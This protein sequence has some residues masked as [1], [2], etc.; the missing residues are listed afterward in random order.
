MK[1]LKQLQKKFKKVKKEVNE[2][3]LIDT[4]VF[5]EKKIR[6]SKT[7]ADW[8]AEFGEAI[9]FFYSDMDC[10]RKRP[11]GVIKSVRYDGF[12]DNFCFTVEIEG[13]SSLQRIGLFDFDIV[14]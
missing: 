3:G 8:V 10:Y 7:Y 2:I 4:S 5:L 9:G 13:I 14:N 12:E 11:Y 6:I 1:E